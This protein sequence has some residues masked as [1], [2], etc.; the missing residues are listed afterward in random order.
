MDFTISN[1]KKQENV[2]DYGKNIYLHA[3]GKPEKKHSKIFS[4]VCGLC[5]FWD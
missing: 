5:D 3:G 1:E 2:N 4:S